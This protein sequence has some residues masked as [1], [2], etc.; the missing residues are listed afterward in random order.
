MK[1]PLAIFGAGLVLRLIAIAY[2]ARV[3]PQML[4]WGTNEAGGIAR[5]I[6]TNHTFSSPFHDA[7]GPT[8]WIAPIYPGIVAAIFLVFGIQT[9]ASALAVMCFNAI[10]SAAT[11]VIV[12]KIGKE[13]H[14]ENGGVFAGWMWAL[15]PY[16]AILPYILWDTALSALLGAGAL[17]LTMRLASSSRTSSSRTWLWGAGGATWGVSALINPALLA[18]LPVLA[19]CLLDRGR[20]WKEVLVMAISTVVIVTPWIVRNYIVFEEFVPI[21][22]NGL[23]E[24]YFANCGFA[25]H[26]LGPSMEY[27]TLG[28]AAFTAQAGR[29][30][31]EYVRSHP[32]TFLADSVRRA[33]WFWIYPLNFWPLSVLIDLGALAGLTL[34]IGKSRN[35][36]LPLLAV[37]AVYPLIYYASQVVSRY[38]H[39]IDPILYALSGVAL[40]GMVPRSAARLFGRGI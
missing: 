27:Q 37:L 40:S 33:M 34:V 2:L 19:L 7:H 6:V 32:A 4:S 29:R 26:P 38:R 8:A 24:V 1:R 22:S 21:R 35:S 39:P 28:E 9:P 11:G 15:S 18:P 17:L 5:W 10:A 14:S 13:I 25:T 36:A 3:T 23:T 16:V 20:K 30:A 12:F 31:I